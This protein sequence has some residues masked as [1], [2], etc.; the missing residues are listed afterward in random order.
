MY[1]TV[2]FSWSEY[3][4]SEEIFLNNAI[5]SLLEIIPSPFP[6]TASSTNSKKHENGLSGIKFY[7]YPKG[8]I[9]EKAGGKVDAL[10]E[11][12]TDTAVSLIALVLKYIDIAY[13]ASAVPRLVLRHRRA[14]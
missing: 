14:G 12:V 10:P 9:E 7:Q 13:P 1:F 2:S 8:V 5:E 3:K 4:S 6:C 11:G